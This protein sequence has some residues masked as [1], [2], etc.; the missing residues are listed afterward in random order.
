[1]NISCRN[2][3]SSEKVMHLR[4]LERTRSEVEDNI[5]GAG[6]IRRGLDRA[7]PRSLQ[8]TARTTLGH[9]LQPVKP[10]IFIECH[11]YSRYMY[12]TNLFYMY[13]GYISRVV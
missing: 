4:H 2:K 1:M 7:M 10:S 13:F 12:G 5:L 3:D 6:Q 8:E 11:S 9:I